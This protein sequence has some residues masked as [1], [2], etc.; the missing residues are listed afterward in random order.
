MRPLNS[1]ISS[2]KINK[3]LLSGRQSLTPLLLLLLSCI[4]LLPSVS[5]ASSWKL[6]EAL[7]E[8]VKNVYPWPE[9]MI[10][11]IVVKGDIP[12]MKPSKIIVQRGLPG[13]TIFL[14]EFNSSETLSVSANVKA[15]DNVI[16]VKRAFKKGYILQKDDIY[17]V[18]MD[19]QRIPA[20]ALKEIKSILGKSLNRSILPNTPV[21]AQ[22]LTDS[23]TVRKGKKVVL[24][25]EGENFRISTTG[26][27][28]ESGSV[29]D[30]V[31]ALNI[32]SKKVITGLLVDENTLKVEL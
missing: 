4:N 8:Y 16:S 5:I 19:V 24:L 6:E 14:L 12:D 22:M 30:Y 13:K 27:V 9:I 31:K 10:S 11:D 32:S 15:F 2:K 7:K 21:T 28:K 26:E 17:T 25:V 29:G 23:C 1:K 3:P 18:L 20:G